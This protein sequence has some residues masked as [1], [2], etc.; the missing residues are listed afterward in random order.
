LRESLAALGDVAVDPG[1]GAAQQL[2]DLVL[3]AAG[4]AVRRCVPSPAIEHSKLSGPVNELESTP[5]V[6]TRPRRLPSAARH[7]EVKSPESAPAKR[8]HLLSA[9]KDAETEPDPDTFDRVLTTF[10]RRCGANLGVGNLPMDRP[11]AETVSLASPVSKRV[12]Y[13]RPR[14]P[15][16]GRV[17][18]RTRWSNSR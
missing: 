10:R 6:P 11:V 18:G 17:R 1:V 12:R 4:G 7:D 3:A 2:I 13:A 8:A 16:A 5:P 14:G 9:F 15:R